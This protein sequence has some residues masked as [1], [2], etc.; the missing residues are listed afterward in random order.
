MYAHVAPFFLTRGVDR[1]VYCRSPDT[2]TIKQKM[3]YSS[4]KD[5]LKKAFGPGVAKEIQANDHGDLQ[6][7]SVL[8]IC[9]RTDRD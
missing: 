7:S 3:L 9:K 2:A 1:Y 4:S 8:E 5:A 6:W